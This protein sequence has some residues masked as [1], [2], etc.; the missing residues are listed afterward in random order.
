MLSLLIEI[1]F[2]LEKQS[3]VAMTAAEEKSQ[4]GLATDEAKELFARALG[5]ADGYRDAMRI[6]NQQITLLIG[7]RER[8][9][10]INGPLEDSLG[11]ERSDGA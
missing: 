11:V 7:E 2:Q 10:I 1:L 6:V 9:Q 8:E 3:D 4:Q 5:Q